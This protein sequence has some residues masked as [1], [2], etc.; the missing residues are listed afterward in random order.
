MDIIQSYDNSWKS[1]EE[2]LE[3]RY[4]I[5]LKMVGSNKKVL[6]IGCGAGLLSSLISNQGNEV[7]GVDIS[8]EALRKAASRGIE[9]RQCNIEEGLPFEDESFDMVVCSEIIEHLFAPKKLLVEIRRALRD[10]GFLILTTPNVTYIV[11]RI[12]FLLGK[13][14]EEA[15]WATTS[16]TNE[17]EHIRFFTVSSLEKLLNETGFTIMEFKG[18]DR[19]SKL[20]LSRVAKGL[21][22]QGFVIKAKKGFNHGIK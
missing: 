12:C 4:P 6:D 9:V 22:A 2:K 14:P 18:V 19:F 5:I 1:Q 17:W 3:K 16:C 11:R 20:P 10:D 15:K 7:Y 13:F 8:S 21:F